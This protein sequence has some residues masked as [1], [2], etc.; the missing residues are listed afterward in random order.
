MKPVDPTAASSHRH[1]AG[2][3]YVCA[4]ELCE[5][6]AASLLASLLVLYLNE[7][8][9]MSQGH[10]TRLGGAFSGIAYVSSLAGGVLADRVLGVRRAIMLG[11]LLLAVGY[12]V[13]AL[14]RAA[15]LYP[16][17]VLLVAGQALFKPNLTAIVGKLYAPDDTRRGE[18]YG[19]FYT[20][21]NVSA[22]TAPL[23]GGALRSTYGW[24]VAF[25]A[26]SVAM[27][28]ALVVFFIGY[29]RISE[30]VEGAERCSDAYL[31]A[32]AVVATLVQ[33]LPMLVGLLMATLLFTATFE[34]S[35]Q[36]LVFW[37]RD[38][39]RRI[40]FGHTVPP[41][42]LLAV[43]G[44][45]VLL[46][47]P[48]LSLVMR[49][50]RARGREPSSLAKIGAGAVFSAFAYALMIW[51]ALRQHGAGQVSALWL[52]GCFFVLTIG[53]LLFYPIGMAL[54]TSLVPV[55]AAAGAMG[56]WFVA[57]ALGQWLAGE[58]GALWETWPHPR[59][60]AMLAGASLGALGFLALSSRRI[61]QTLS[62]KDRST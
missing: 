17:L 11:L 8:L 54:V 45:A 21:I 13:L 30:G 51:A 39:T 47:Q 34:Q 58:S 27:L 32:R 48:A 42:Y 36:S 23:A 38:C 6:F 25:A 24:G 12:V 9:G 62:D 43:P 1:P 33:T 60:F 31:E 56:L 20:A 16:A 4:V 10:A 40:V 2:L 18:A 61:A 19:V 7:R 29:R 53:E 35:G 28:L 14:D 26:A 37:A 52:L 49:L 57:I 59:F 46:M 50:L 15:T 5:R 44:A 3:I 41:S 55:R 22:A